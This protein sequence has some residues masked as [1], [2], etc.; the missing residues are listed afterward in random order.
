MSRLS[1]AKVCGG[2][3]GGKSVPLAL[4]DI[5]QDRLQ[6]VHGQAVRSQDCTVSCSVQ[7]PLSRLQAFIAMCTFE[8]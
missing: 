8:T 7:E 2:K 6:L 5:P 4:L 1:T 3:V